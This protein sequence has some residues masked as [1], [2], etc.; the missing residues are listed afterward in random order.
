MKVL[1]VHQNFP[2]QFKH[3]AP[4]LVAAGHEAHALAIEGKPVPGV[5]FYRYRLSRGNSPNIHPLAVEFEA[6]LIR[7]EAC[8]QAMM[9]LRSSRLHARRGGGP[10]RL[11]RNPVRQGC[12]AGDA[13]ALLP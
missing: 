8:A 13:A 1:F 2:G 10:P 5:H 12:L 4:A 6:K 3:L 7:G 11:G 9:K